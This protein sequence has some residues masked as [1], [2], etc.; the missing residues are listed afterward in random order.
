MTDGQQAHIH[1]T[2]DND[3]VVLS[4]TLRLSPLL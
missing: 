1:I 4:E 2:N 3:E